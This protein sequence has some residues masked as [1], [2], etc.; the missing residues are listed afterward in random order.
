[1]VYQLLYVGLRQHT[2]VQVALEVDVEE[3]RDTAHG[4]G[5]TVLRL[6]CAEVAEVEPL[7]GLACILCGLADV[8]AIELCHLLQTL[9]R[10]DLLRD[11]LAQADYLVDHLAVAHG[12]Q[13]VLLLLDQVV[14]TIESHTA[15]VTHDT[16]TAIGVGQTREDVVVAHQLH[17]RRISVE[18]TVVMRLAIFREDL[19]QFLRGLITIG[20]AGL[21]SHL[22]TSVGHEGTLQRLVSLQADHL[23]QVLC[24]L[25]D[26]TRAV[27]S[28]A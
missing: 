25:R 23:L 28:Q 19:M 18:H 5:G 12:S 16:A 26:I 22:D 14:D 3:G 13:V 15:V 17:L 27:G 6:H 4:H 9:Q 21:L 7:H 20:R 2:L 24:A 1:M 11:L 8:E 10:L